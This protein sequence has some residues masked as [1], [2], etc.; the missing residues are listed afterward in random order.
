MA[1]WNCDVNRMNLFIV[2]ILKNK[3]C[4]EETR[5]WF[6]MISFRWCNHPT[7]DGLCIYSLCLFI[8]TSAKLTCMLYLL[9][10]LLFKEQPFYLSFCFF[11]IWTKIILLAKIRIIRLS[12][13]SQS[14]QKR[15]GTNVSG[16]TRFDCISFS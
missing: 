2:W 7:F 14:G 9:L 5:S 12:G 11:T 3:L 4:G 16:L 10:C 6:N 1:V 8:H 13:Y 15:V